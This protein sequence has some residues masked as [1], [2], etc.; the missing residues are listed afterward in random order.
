MAETHLV[1]KVDVLDAHQLPFWNNIMQAFGV[2]LIRSLA[3]LPP[4]CNQELFVVRGKDGRLSRG[5]PGGVLLLYIWRSCTVS[6]SLW[7]KLETCN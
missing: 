3:T 6:V 5:L 2:W 1:K 4:S 7:W